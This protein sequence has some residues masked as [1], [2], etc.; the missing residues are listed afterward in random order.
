MVHVAILLFLRR[1]SDAY[2]FWLV[3]PPL[4]RPH[5]IFYYSVHCPTISVS[6]IC[7]WPTKLLQWSYKNR[8]LL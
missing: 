1:L 3:M 4:N 8:T 6:K 5:M 2:N 7:I